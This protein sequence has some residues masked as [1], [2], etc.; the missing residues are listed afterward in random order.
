[1]KQQIQIFVTK[2]LSL[3]F[4]AL[5]V[6]IVTTGAISQ[7]NNGDADS[8]DPGVRGG[9]PAAGGPRANLSANYQSMFTASPLRFQEVDSVAGAI[10]GE[11][12]TGLGP[13]FNS[14]SCASCHAQPAIGGSS[15]AVNPQFSMANL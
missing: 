14:N 4:F 13:G 11:T 10:P 9:P 7:N 2:R 1:M 8:L 6:S 12:G 15:P 5:A 3:L